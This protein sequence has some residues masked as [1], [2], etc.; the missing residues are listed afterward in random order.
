MTVRKLISALEKLSP[1]ARVTLTR[2]FASEELEYLKAC[3]ALGEP[4]TYAGEAV[5]VAHSL[6][7]IDEV[8]IGGASLMRRELGGEGEG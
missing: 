6:G 7:R 3:E 4:A 2:T 5:F 8:L 1:E